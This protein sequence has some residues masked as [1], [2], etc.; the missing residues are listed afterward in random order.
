MGD[1]QVQNEKAKH[2]Y[3]EKSKKKKSNALMSFPNR[4]K[5]LLEESRACAYKYKY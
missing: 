1:I 2:L 3:Q 4:K 5:K